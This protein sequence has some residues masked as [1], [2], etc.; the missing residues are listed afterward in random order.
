MEYDDEEYD[1]EFEDDGEDD[2]IEN[3]EIDIENKKETEDDPD[4]DEEDVDINDEYE[5]PDNN[6]VKSNYVLGKLTKYE[7]IVLL[8]QRMEQIASG[9]DV[10]CQINDMTNLFEIVREEYNNKK[11]PL[12]ILRS[13][14]TGLFTNGY[15]CVDPFKLHNDKL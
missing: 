11:I 3:E 1:Q 12:N 5:Q 7:M 2:G 14:P 15:Y 13:V 4:D 6:Q 8:G 9:A 10:Y